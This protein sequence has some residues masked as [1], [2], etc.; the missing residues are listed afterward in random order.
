MARNVRIGEGRARI[1][2]VRTYLDVPPSYDRENFLFGNRR[3]I[4]GI[5]IIPKNRIAELLTVM[6]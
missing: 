6:S 3:R 1:N 5:V 4:T 2:R